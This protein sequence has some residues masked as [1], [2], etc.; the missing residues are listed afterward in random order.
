MEDY[1]KDFDGWNKEKQK[2]HGK[3]ETL[4]FNEGEIWWCALG[5]NIDIEMDGKSNL[6][7]SYKSQETFKKNSNG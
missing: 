5:V 6:F 3:N 7:K 2:I 1:I 4:F